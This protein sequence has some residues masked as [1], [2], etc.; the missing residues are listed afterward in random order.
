M[1]RICDN[2]QT[3]NPV[4]SRVC[5]H[6][7]ENISDITPTDISQTDLAGKRTFSL[8]SIDGEE[9]FVFDK[10]V[11]EVGRDHAM[12]GEY[13]YLAS[14][15]QVSG[16]HALFTISKSGE[17]YVTD[18]SRNG[19]YVNGERIG[20]DPVLLKDGDDIGLGGFS[21]TDEKQQQSAYFVV[22]V[23]E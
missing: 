1:V 20:L 18:H 14:K 2:C 19:T 21:P 8:A 9:I 11:T 12:G 16:A 10:E 17:L 13:G 15:A 3:Q 5:S 23:E 7:K 22:R 4:S 6:C